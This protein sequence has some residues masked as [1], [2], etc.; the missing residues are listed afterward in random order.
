MMVDHFDI[1]QQIM[2]IQ[3]VSGHEEEI[4]EVPIT[5]LATPWSKVRLLYRIKEGRVYEFIC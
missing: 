5:M 4:N 3:K 2:T 1:Y